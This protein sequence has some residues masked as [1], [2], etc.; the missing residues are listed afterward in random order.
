M[1]CSLLPYLLSVCFLGA[2]LLV[3]EVNRGIMQVDLLEVECFDLEMQSIGGKMIRLPEKR[4]ERH[5]P[6]WILQAR[7]LKKMMSA[8]RELPT[9][10]CQHLLS[11][12]MKSLRSIL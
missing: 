12:T 3:S 7:L 1:G 8:P 9:V 4:V 11:Q 2:E 5:V 6:E 10:K